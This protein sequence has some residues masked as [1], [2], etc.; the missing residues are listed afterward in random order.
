MLAGLY[1]EWFKNFREAELRLGPLTVIVGTNASGKSN[2]RDAFRFLHGIALGYTVAD[3]MG[4]KY[5]GGSLQWS[6]I[7]GGTREVAFAGQSRFALAASFS[8]HDN[9]DYQP[10]AIYRIEIE[11]SAPN[12][13]PRV[14]A[15]RLTVQGQGDYIFDSHPAVDPPRQTNPML[16]SVKLRARGRSGRLPAEDFNALQPILSQIPEHSKVPTLV[17]DYAEQCIE[18]F[19]SMRFLDLSSEAM[20]R[21]SL[22]GQ[23]ILGDRGENLSSVLQAICQQPELKEALVEWVQ[24]LR[25]RLKLS[26]WG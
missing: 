13:I 5:I 1:L 8:T 11:I 4:E 3:I 20:R 24:E 16:L 19:S 12:G 17:R 15:E 26:A 25:A 7:R 10:N 9:P 6:G 21:P 14:A 23:T 18:Q 22:P 2:I